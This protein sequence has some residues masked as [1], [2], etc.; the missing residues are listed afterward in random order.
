MSEVPDLVEQKKVVRRL[1]DEGINGWNLD[2]VDELF[3]PPAA[4]RARRDFSSFKSAFPDWH[5]ELAEMIS[6]GNTVVARFR[7]QGT[8][9]G[10]WLGADPTGRKMEVDEVFFFHFTDRR[11]SDMWGLEDTRTREQQLGI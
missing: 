3:E 8:H 6:E 4:N 10:R 2:V 5:M 11:I 9:L 1:V 7:C